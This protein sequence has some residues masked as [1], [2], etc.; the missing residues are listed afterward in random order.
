MQRR[1]RSP[2]LGHLRVTIVSLPTF[3]VGFRVLLLETCFWLLLSG[4]LSKEAKKAASKVEMPKYLDS[5]LNSD[6]QQ[7]QQRFA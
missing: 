4:V 3:G 1:S 7:R 2:W 5:V 6:G